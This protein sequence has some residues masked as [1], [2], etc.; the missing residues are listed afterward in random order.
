M[1][2]QN[3]CPAV[4]HKAT[5]EGEKLLQE[6]QVSNHPA[7]RLLALFRARLLIRLG[8]LDEAARLVEQPTDTRELATFQGLTQA[9]LILA[10]ASRDSDLVSLSQLK[11]LLDDE[12][13][14]AETIGWTRD[15]IESLIIRT[16]THM[17]A[18]E[19]QA[20]NADLVRALSLAA[21]ERY[22]RLF[23]DEGAPIEQLLQR[24][25][26]TSPSSEFVNDLLIAFAAEAQERSQDPRTPRREG[27][28]ER[29]V[30]PLPLSSSM[31]PLIEALTERELELLCLV[32]AGHS[33]QQIA[34]ELFLAIGTVKKHLN[35]IFGKLG[36][37]SRTQAVARAREIDLL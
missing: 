30:P 22:M 28:A 1:G 2:D 15:V 33:N 19:R 17:V 21:P 34:Q 13:G 18:G 5:D 36:V 23:L 7:L 37:S 11:A 25:S 6:R 10:Q 26:Q 20:A 4:R 12:L 16:L 3:A 24:V 29:Q 8:R 27:A 14:Q 9:R 31:P 32:A 35:N